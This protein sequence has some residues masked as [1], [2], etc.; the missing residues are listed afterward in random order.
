VAAGK[1]IFS[2]AEAPLNPV[3]EARCGFTVPPR[4]P[5]ALAEAVIKLYQ[6][7]PNERVEM[8]KRGREYVEKYPDIRKLAMQLESVLHSVQ[9]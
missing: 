3:K 7:S 2:S 1:P 5:E 4:N 9:G 6:M 8:G